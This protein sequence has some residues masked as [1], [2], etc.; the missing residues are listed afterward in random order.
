MLVAEA[1][2]RSTQNASAWRSQRVIFSSLTLTFLINVILHCLSIYIHIY[3][4][5]S[6]AEAPCCR[7]GA[8]HQVLQTRL[9]FLIGR[10]HQSTNA[11]HQSIIN[12]ACRLHSCNCLM[13]STD[14]YLIIDGLDGVLTVVT[15]R[16]PSHARMKS[17]W[18][19]FSS[20][21]AAR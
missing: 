3:M 15:G 20:S 5:Q 12:K 7:A 6:S 14:I 13:I 9:S 17:F 4:H 18:T 11:P 2:E 21:S 10:T 8:H 16:A 19:A 1:A